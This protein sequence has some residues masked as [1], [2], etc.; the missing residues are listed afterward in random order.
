[1]MNL[2]NKI[3]GENCKVSGESIYVDDKVFEIKKNVIHLQEDSGYTNNFSIQWKKFSKTQ[4]DDYSGIKDTEER[5]KKNIGFDLNIL[6][7]KVVFEIGSGPGRFTEIF[8]KYGAKVISLDYSE[9]IYVNSENNNSDDIIFIKGSLFDIKAININVDLIFC[10]GVI[11]HTPDP[12]NTVRHIIECANNKAVISID[13][14]RKFMLPNVWSSPK[15]FWRPISTR[16]SPEL[17]LVIIEKYIPIW[18]PIDNLIRRI[19]IFGSRILSIIP[20]PCWNYIDK[21]LTKKQRKEWAIMDTF[22]ALGA[23]YDKP[24][25][26]RGFKNLLEKIQQK[27]ELDFSI[28]VFHGSNGVVANITWEK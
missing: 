8:L 10:Y 12:V 17:L 6:K 2:Y 21:G 26:R 11:Q 23:A 14:Y 13:V 22:D 16:I 1:M 24:F 28:H 3:F 7:D 18:L 27:L 9:A 4:L 25:T 15:Y 5:L 19:P 20:I